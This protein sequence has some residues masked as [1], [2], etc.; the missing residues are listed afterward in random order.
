MISREDREKREQRKER[1]KG[2]ERN[3][4]ESEKGKTNQLLQTRRKATQTLQ[5]PAPLRIRERERHTEHARGES[6]KREAKGGQERATKEGKGRRAR[7]SARV[8]LRAPHRGHCKL[9]TEREWAIARVRESERE[10][11]K[12][13]RRTKKN[14]GQS[15][16]LQKRRN[17]S[18]RSAVFRHE[19]GA[20]RLRGE[21]SLCRHCSGRG[22]CVGEEKE[23]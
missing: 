4:R 8:S 15:K 20:R 1:R 11:K 14:E 19:E 16:N 13:E 2:G 9:S 23:C 21:A 5:A 7:P 18:P 3:Q 6:E 10:T 17:R 12:A 22:S